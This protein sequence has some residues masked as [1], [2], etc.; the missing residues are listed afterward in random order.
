MILFYAPQMEQL[1]REIS[2][3]SHVE[4]FMAKS[5]GGLI[6]L[7][8]ISWE[9]FDNQTPNTAIENAESIRGQ[10]VGFLASFDQRRSECDH[11]LPHAG[12]FQQ[13]SVIKTLPDLLA[14]TVRVILPYFSFGPKD[15]ADRLGDVVNAQTAASMIE[16]PACHGGGPAL[17]VTYDIHALQEEHYFNKTVRIYQNRHIRS[18]AR[19]SGERSSA[20]KR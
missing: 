6:E 18:S 16:I 9:K 1:A 20:K 11:E 14:D 19:K 2:R 4:P 15:R 17:L 8:R 3:W 7:G 5:R 10:R 12:F 13:L